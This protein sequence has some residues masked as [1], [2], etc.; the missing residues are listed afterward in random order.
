LLVTGPLVGGLLGAVRG[1]EP[2]QRPNLWLV[3]ELP[4]E[5]VPGDFLDD[6]RRSPHLVVIEEHVAQGGLGQMIALHLVSI[7]LAPWRFT[8]R[9]ALGYVSGRYGS[10]KFHRKECGLDPDSILGLLTG[11]A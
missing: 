9:A 1:M 5:P 6:V 8:S 2:D 3:T 4:I 7:G 10:Q 11:S